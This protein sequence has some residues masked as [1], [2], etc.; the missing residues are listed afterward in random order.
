MHARGVQSPA[1]SWSP[2]LSCSDG[3]VNLHRERILVSPDD[4]CST[5]SRNRGYPLVM[6]KLSWMTVALLLV[7][8][9]GGS[10]KP[11]DEPYEP[12]QVSDEQHQNDVDPFFDG[13]T[14]RSK[15]KVDLDEDDPDEEADSAE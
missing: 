11:A 4:R 6:A 2:A 9:C 3:F 15:E 1:L 12:E 7:S 10:K 8:A 5:S 14:N 13:E